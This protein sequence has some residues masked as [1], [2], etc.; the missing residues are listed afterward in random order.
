MSDRNRGKSSR[1]K[2]G[3]RSG[4]GTQAQQLLGGLL[5]RFTSVD[6]VLRSVDDTVA[7]LNR[8]VRELSQALDEQTGLDIDVTQT[9]PAERS[10]DLSQVV[11]ANTSANQ[12]VT[13]EFNIPADGTITRILLGWPDGAQQAVGIGVDGVNGESL[14]PAGPK[15]SRYV[16]LNDKVVPFNLDDSVSKND[17]YTVRFANNDDTNDHFVNVLI[18][19][20]RDA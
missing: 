9:P 10:Y 16:A 11:P 5:D 12:P 6:D 7:S 14:I 1:G 19:H 2:R 20:A 15:D 17:T 3:G 8:N 13:D 18:F 4:D